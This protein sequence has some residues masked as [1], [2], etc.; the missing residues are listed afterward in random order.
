MV[1]LRRR[2]KE[3]QSALPE[4]VRMLAVLLQAGAVPLAAWRHLAESGVPAAA[5]VVASVERGATIADA[6]RE[7]GGV[8]R[9][10]AAAWAIAS[11][12][13]APLGDVLRVV[14]DA[15]DDALSTADEIRVALA[16]PSGTAR[17]LLWL[18]GVGVLLGTALGFDTLPVLFGHPLGLVC[19]A[20]GLGLT[21]LARLWTS[22]LVR[23]ARPRPGVP[24]MHAELLAVALSGGASISRA[25]ALVE[26]ESD[27]AE[28]T[29]PGARD[30]EGTSLDRVL[31][32][33]AS[34]GVPAVDLLRAEAARARRAERV[35]GRLGA[36]RLSTRLLLPLGACTL[37]A[38]LLLGVAPL[39]LSVLSTTPL[40]GGL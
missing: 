21:L 10:V 26:E 39:A 29:T 34:A 33:S 19:L 31:R 37:P 3:G 32:L 5:A 15:L 4:E 6:V 35:R 13:G 25:T 9:E 27:A 18:P 7:R 30:G 2:T 20:T 36:S 23:R 24:G 1:S 11:T 12:V 22:A 40:P 14:A 8:W 38:F 16:E 17:L 28:V